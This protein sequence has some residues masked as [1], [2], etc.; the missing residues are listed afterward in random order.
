ML[1]DADHA[2]GWSS[3]PNDE[4]TFVAEGKLQPIGEF[5]IDDGEE[6]RVLQC[7]FAACIRAV[8]E[9]EAEGIGRL[10]PGSSSFHEI[11]FVYVGELTETGL[12]KGIGEVG[13]C[14]SVP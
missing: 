4:E 7:G 9:D 2:K 8:A 5:A 3:L 13:C 11:R 14:Q 12:F 6:D 10:V 1:A